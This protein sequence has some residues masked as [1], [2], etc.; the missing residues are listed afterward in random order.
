MTRERVESLLL[1]PNSPPIVRVGEHEIR[2]ECPLVTAS[3]IRAVLQ[4]V[5]TEEKLARLE[6]NGGEVSSHLRDFPYSCRATSSANGLE[7]VFLRD[8][9]E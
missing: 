6:S 3:E 8:A 2:L 5:F 4:D 1:R 9:P 7:L